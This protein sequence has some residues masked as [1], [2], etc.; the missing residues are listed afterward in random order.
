MTCSE[1]QREN[2][3]ELYLDGKLSGADREAFELHYFECDAC[4]ADMQAL[5]AARAALLEMGEQEEPPEGM[6]LRHP[7]WIAAA[8]AASLVAAIL[9]W[10]TIHQQPAPQ[11]AVQPSPVSAPLLALN[12]IQPPPYDVRVLRGQ[13]TPAQQAFR[14]A[15]ARYS[16]SDWNAT[17]ALLTSVLEKFPDASDAIYFRAICQL[18]SGQTSAALDGLDRIV[19]LG[20]ATPYEE[21]ARFYR[22]Q[23]YLLQNRADDARQE[24]DYVAGMHGDH[25]AKARA[26]LQ[27]QSP[28]ATKPPQ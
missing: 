15:M 3:I 2:R 4:L 20:G 26:L 12:E 1:I 8:L 27:R 28:T 21:E 17:A 11:Q 18:L 10:Q 19:M 14:A 22:A 13:S 6:V 7:V 24:L 23:A 16:Q 9:T 25:E 5:Q